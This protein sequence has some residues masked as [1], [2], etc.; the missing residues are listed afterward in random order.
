MCQ[1]KYVICLGINEQVNPGS[2]IWLPNVRSILKPYCEPCICMDAYFLKNKKSLFYCAFRGSFSIRTC[3]SYIGR[4]MC[5]Y[6]FYNSKFRNYNLKVSNLDAN[7]SL[8][9]PFWATVRS[10]G[11]GT[12]CC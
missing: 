4:T 2:K 6:S 12:A 10:T 11:C 5:L 3:G 8:L 7:A 9:W 1:V